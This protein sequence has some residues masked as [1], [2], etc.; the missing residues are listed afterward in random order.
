MLDLTAAEWRTSTF[1]DLNGCIEVTLLD[2]R[3]AVRDSKDRAGPVLVFS[4][5]EW[6]AFLAGVRTGEFDLT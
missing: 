3:V 2:G 4:A 5:N 1:C 6:E